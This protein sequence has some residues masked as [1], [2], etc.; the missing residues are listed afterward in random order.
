[1][2]PLNRKYPRQI[3][4]DKEVTQDFEKEEKVLLTGD[5]S[6]HVG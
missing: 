5:K 4:S 6:F 3:H 2:V 1:M